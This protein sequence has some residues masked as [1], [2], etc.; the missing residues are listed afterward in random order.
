MG[1]VGD[2]I[3]LETWTTFT[4]QW[5]AQNSIAAVAWCPRVQAGNTTDFDA[6]ARKAYPHITE[7]VRIYH[8]TATGEAVY[9]DNMTDAEKEEMWPI[10]YV[11]PGELDFMGIDMGSGW[12]ANAFDT[13]LKTNSTA[14]TEV[15]IEPSTGSPLFNVIQPV[16]AD[17][18]PRADIIGCIIKGTEIS[19]FIFE[20]LD[21]M[22]FS[23]R[24]P[25]ASVALFL[26][27]GEVHQLLFD[28]GT[29]PDGTAEA[30]YAGTVTPSVVANRGSESTISVVSLTADKSIVVVSSF[31]PTRNNRR[32]LPALIAGCVASLLVASLV[33][34]RQVL[35]LSYKHGME[36]ATMVSSFKSRFVADMSHEIR[37]PLNGIIGTADLL[38]EEPLSTNARDLLRTLQACCNVLLGM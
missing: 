36:R 23:T 26:K 1:L 12:R 17:A 7:G 27:V 13:V 14:L 2:A 31:G 18:Y 20:I 32:S 3:T 19:Y 34:G 6:A 25:S 22:A 15:A 28:L 29:Y 21:G 9:M 24:Y 38:T 35:V 30:F 4:D 37:T 8:I 16:F 10:L 11:N 5:M 33:Y